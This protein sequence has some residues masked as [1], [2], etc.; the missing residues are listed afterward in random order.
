MIRGG[1]AADVAGVNRDDVPVLSEILMPRWLDTWRQFVAIGAFPVAQLASA[2]AAASSRRS[3]RIA[4]ITSSTSASGAASAAN[5]GWVSTG[6][7][8]HR[9]AA[10]RSDT[11]LR[12]RCGSA[13]FQRL[14]RWGRAGA[15]SAGRMERE[16]SA[17]PI[18]VNPLLVSGLRRRRADADRVAGSS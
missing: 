13:G 1:C 9:R 12:G 8:L 7:A 10:R 18:K 11:R 5:R 4:A 6:L 14:N 2:R 16:E 3:R 15:E 17:M